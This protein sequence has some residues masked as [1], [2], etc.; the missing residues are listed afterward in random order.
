MLLL[1][2]QLWACR[3]SDPVLSG[4]GND[5]GAGEVTTA[6][7]AL[8]AGVLVDLPL[9]AGAELDTVRGRLNEQMG[10]VQS[11][12]TLGGGQGELLTL[13]R[14]QVWVQDGRIYQLRVDLDRP[15]RREA[16]LSSLNI[17]P[18]VD[19]PAAL[20]D[21]IRVQWHQGFERLRLGRAERWSEMVIWVEL[22]AFDPREGG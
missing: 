1:L 14:G 20:S 6:P 22:R 9:F 11:K 16:A 10:D 3:S 21:E 19:R 5:P 18:R 2:L 8:S 7:Y 15:T 13:E 12:Q 17:D 4:V